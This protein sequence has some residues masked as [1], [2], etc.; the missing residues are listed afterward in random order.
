MTAST[1]PDS[2]NAL[3]ASGSSN[4]P[5]THASVTSSSATLDCRQAPPDTVE[6]PVVTWSLKR[7]QTTATPQP[8][9]V[10]VR[11]LGSPAAR[12]LAPIVRVSAR[13]SS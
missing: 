9:A 7:P 4:A 3:A 2:A 12:W 8:A 11:L 5:G 1:A 6:Q 13:P 10:E